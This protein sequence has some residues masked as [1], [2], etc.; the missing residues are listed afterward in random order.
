MYVKAL[1]NAFNKR[2]S[3]LRNHLLQCT[4][5]CLT[6]T[7]DLLAQFILDC[8]YSSPEFLAHRFHLGLGSNLLPLPIRSN[9]HVLLELCNS[10]GLLFY[11]SSQFGCLLRMNSYRLR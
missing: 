1:F 3:L 10:K 4:H 5:V 8:C 2:T 6:H 7:I 11:C 9:H